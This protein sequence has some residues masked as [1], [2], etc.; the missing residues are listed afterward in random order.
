MS[1]VSITPTLLSKLKP[2]T[3]PY[4]ARD[5][6]LKGF[7]IKVNPSGSVRF[8]AEVKSKGR[9]RRKVIGTHPILSLQDAKSEA[10]FFISAVKS[11]TA[12]ESCNNIVLHAMLAQYLSGGR[13]KPRT[14][15]DYQE[16]IGFYLSDWVDIKVS[17][18]TKEMVEKR[19]YRI[20]DK[21]INGGIPTY[22]QAT[23][24]MRILSALMYYAMADGIIESNPVHVL[25]QKRI[26]RSIIKRTSYLAQEDA[27][28]VLES[29]STHSVEIAVELLCST[30]AMISGGVLQ[31][32][33][34]K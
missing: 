26:D 6:N 24:V 33:L 23:K 22:S 20:R 2:T 7:G 25:K 16:A 32:E 11:G 5:S 30:G 17:A 4:F 28:K 14:I 12:V 8:I 1:H 27:R 18:I 29:L 21:G 3:K 19:F 10:L 9:S 15:Q 13:L 34:Q 31:P